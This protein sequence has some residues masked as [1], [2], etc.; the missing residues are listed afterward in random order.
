MDNTSPNISE[1]INLIM[2]NPQMLNMIKNL[3]GTVGNTSDAEGAP[4]SEKLSSADEVNV[5][6]ELIE[7]PVPDETPASA[8]VG[9]IM[10]NRDKG[11]RRKHLL[12]A[13]KPYVSKERAKAIDSMLSIAELFDVIRRG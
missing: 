4:D 12:C 11:A 10:H 9:A 1:V 2:Q 8:E 3:A 13:L 5:A 7:K 6:P